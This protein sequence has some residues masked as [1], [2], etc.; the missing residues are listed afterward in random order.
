M[1]TQKKM[2][3]TGYKV[4]RRTFGGY[5]SINAI[6]P[7]HYK[8]G[9]WVEAVL[10]SRL[11]FFENREAANDFI[12]ELQRAEGMQVW[13]CEVEGVQEIVERCEVHY[14]PMVADEMFQEY[15]DKFN[16][17]PK[18]LPRGQFLTYTAPKDTLL[19]R[20]VKLTK[21]VDAY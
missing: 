10:N 5:K 20:R 19:A 15:W 2:P 7:V 12:L 3:T 16:G 11:F 14:N 4:V 8:V 18:H 21:L 9:E 13:E 1:E 17:D 6:W